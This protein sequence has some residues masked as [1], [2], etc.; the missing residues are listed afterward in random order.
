MPEYA[1]VEEYAEHIRRETGRLMASLCSDLGPQHPSTVKVLELLGEA[2]N[3]VQ[4]RQMAQEV[5]AQD[6]YDL[7]SLPP[8][9]D[10]ERPEWLTDE[11]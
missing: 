8:P 4:S 11:D 3:I 10:E 5:S 6:R 9:S 2:T 7:N 1:S